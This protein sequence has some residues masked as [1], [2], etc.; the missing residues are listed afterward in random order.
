MKDLK[1][2]SM[3]SREVVSKVSNEVVRTPT[4]VR[5]ILD[6]AEYFEIRD[7]LA[8]AASATAQPRTKKGIRDKCKRPEE[9]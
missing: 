2:L 4:H 7:L 1:T 6:A 5:Q 9:S 3:T 8:K